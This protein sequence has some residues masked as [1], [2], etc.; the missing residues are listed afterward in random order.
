MADTSGEI[1]SWLLRS[2]SEQLSQ[3]LEAMAGEAPLIELLDGVDPSGPN[4]QGGELRFWESTY[5]IEPGAAIVL[6]AANSSW[7]QV[8]GKILAAAGLELDD[9]ET[10]LSTFQETIDQAFSGIAQAATKKARREVNTT[11][12]KQVAYSVKPDES[13]CQITLAFSD[14]VNVDAY[15]L[16]TPPLVSGLASRMEEPAK[17]AP[18]A[19]RQPMAAAAVVS[20]APVQPARQ[21]TKNADLLFDV[22]L[23]V[24]ISFGRAHLQL[25]D[26]MKLTTGSVVELNRTVSEPVEVIVNNC[27]IARGEVVVVEGNFGV[28][29]HE[30]ISRQERLRTLH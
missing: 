9:A 16:A 15:L 28:R 13:W 23:P 29:I 19:S 22:E 30:V 24:C 18:Q 11:P 17:P 2:A 5:S 27:V 1:R 14:G 21:D 26:V 12:S 10:L 25:R 4:T 7:R 3:V 8:G 6:A 20:S